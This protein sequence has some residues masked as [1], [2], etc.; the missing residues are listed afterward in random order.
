VG[1]LR[2]LAWFAEA[3]PVA[4]AIVVAPVVAVW[5]FTTG[6]TRHGWIAVAVFVGALVWAPFLIGEMREQLSDDPDAA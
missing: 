5:C 3:V 6:D 2:W 1:C 4:L